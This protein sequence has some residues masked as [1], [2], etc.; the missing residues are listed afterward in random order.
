[1]TQDSAALPGGTRRR[2]GG[3]ELALLVDLRIGNCGTSI[4]PLRVVDGR[5]AVG[6]EDSD[7]AGGSVAESDWNYNVSD[8]MLLLLQ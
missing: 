2:E 6:G 1:M 4:L 5:I 7:L 8:P 3:V